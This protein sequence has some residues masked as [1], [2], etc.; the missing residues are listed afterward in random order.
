MTLNLKNFLNPKI[1]MSKMGEFQELK[2][3]E[4]LEISSLSA[5]L[6]KDGRDDLALFYFTKG[7]KHKWIKQKTGFSFVW[8]IKNQTKQDYLSVRREQF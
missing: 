1:K 7:A 4:G 6:Y 3:I 5:D 8:L 2:P